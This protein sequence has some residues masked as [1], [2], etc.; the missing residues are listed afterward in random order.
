MWDVP[1]KIAWRPPVG[2]RAVVAD[3]G[4]VVVVVSAQSSDRPDVDDGRP[5]GSAVPVPVFPT[6]IP[7]RIWSPRAWVVFGP[8]RGILV[9]TGVLAPCSGVTIPGPHDRA[10]WVA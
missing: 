9:K 10:I 7:R 2:P 3:L 8:E 4:L 1:D 5:S 6:Q